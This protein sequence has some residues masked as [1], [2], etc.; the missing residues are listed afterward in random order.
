MNLSDDVRSGRIKLTQVAEGFF[1]PSVG[2]TTGPHGHNITSVDWV[3]TEPGELF[4]RNVFASS[5]A[6][7]EMGHPAQD[8]SSSLTLVPT[9]DTLGFCQHTGA[10]AP[11]YL[12]RSPDARLNS[13]APF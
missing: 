5:R 9:R 10:V 12:S 8:Q 13:M 4:V 11:Y 3:M 2:M 7:S 1:V 6:Y